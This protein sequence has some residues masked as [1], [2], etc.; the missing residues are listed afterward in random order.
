MRKIDP[1]GTLRRRSALAAV[2]AACLGDHALAQAPQRVFR[3]GVI[4]WE[5]PEASFRRDEVRKAMES[6]GYREGQNVAYE[7]RWAAGSRAKGAEAAAELE[8]LGVAVI[9]VRGPVAFAAKE[10]VTRTPVV[11]SVSDALATGLVTN[12]VRPGGL[13]TGV[14]SSS[15]EMAPKRLE[16]LRD[17][18]PNLTRV[19]FLGSSIDP[20]AETFIRE[21][22]AAATRLGIA[23]V[24]MRVRGTDD[25]PDALERMVGER[26]QAV[27]IQTLFVAS[28]RPFIEQALRRGLPSI[29][30]QPVF[31]ENGALAAFGPDYSHLTERSAAQIDRILK[32]AHPGDI[33]VE[34]PTRFL[35]VV[36]QRTARTLG[37]TLPPSLLIR[38]DEVIE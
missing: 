3:I 19:G 32:G 4:H 10:V 2:F 37:L 31:A 5:G 17:V 7:W 12:L 21:T 22:A 33:P 6:V 36:N 11:F 25:F 13:M 30:D 23:L 16:I 28:S 14:M 27:I 34:T 1:S 8:R 24:P 35:L 15:P 18:M 29:G 9:F 38:A 26:V 20:N